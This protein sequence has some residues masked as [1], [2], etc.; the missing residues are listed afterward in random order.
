MNIHDLYRPFLRHFRTRRMQQVERTCCLT[1]N[2]G[3]LAVGGNPFNWSLVQTRPQITYLNLYAVE[4]LP[5]GLV[6]A[7]GCEQPFR[8]HEFDIVYR[9][10]VVEHLGSF[11]KQQSFAQE[12]R[13]VGRF[14]FTQTP[15]KRFFI[16]PHYIAP[17]VHWLPKWI[18]GVSFVTRPSGGG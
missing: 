8:P 7:D 6:I 15:N 14:Y 1:P 2:T 3:I 11:E 16:E 9:N 17:F 4:G 18:A 12:C 13:R 5:A 10:S